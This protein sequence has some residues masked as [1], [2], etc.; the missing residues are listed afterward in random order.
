[1]KVGTTELGLV[2]I[3]FRRVVSDTPAIAVINTSFSK[4]RPDI[5]LKEFTKTNDLKKPSLVFDIEDNLLGIISKKEI[6]KSHKKTQ[7]QTT[8]ADVMYRKFHT[9]LP[10]DYLFTVIQKMNSHPFDMIPVVD[11]NDS[12]KVVGVVTSEGLMNLLTETKKV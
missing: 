10:D 8:V 9:T 3:F 1:V 6:T 5:T 7:E 2:P 12:R 4:T 11:P